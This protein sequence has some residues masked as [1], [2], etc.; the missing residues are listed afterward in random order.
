MSFSFIT[1]VFEFYFLSC[2]PDFHFHLL[3]PV[4]FVVVHVVYFRRPSSRLW[5]PK[6][7]VGMYAFEC[8]RKQLL[9]YSISLPYS[10]PDVNLIAFFLEVDCHRTVGIDII[11]KFDVHLFYPLFLIEVSTA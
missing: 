9:R 5:F 2:D 3:I 4:A 11:Q 10:S 1:F 7:V 6:S 8:C